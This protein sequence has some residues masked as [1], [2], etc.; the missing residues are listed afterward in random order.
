MAHEHVID[1]I[2]ERESDAYV[3]E[4]E[5]LPAHLVNDETR[6]SILLRGS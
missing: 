3:R 2:R 6:G 4:P 1:V 5:R